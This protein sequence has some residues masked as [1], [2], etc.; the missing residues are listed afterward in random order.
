MPRQQPSPLL[1]GP[2]QTAAPASL[3]VDPVQVFVGMA[4]VLD[5]FRP[6]GHVSFQRCIKSLKA[7]NTTGEETP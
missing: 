4:A 5:F 2:A 1:H 7:A 3:C 6:G